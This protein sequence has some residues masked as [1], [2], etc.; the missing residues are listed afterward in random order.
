[1]TCSLLKRAD[2]QVLPICP[3]LEEPS[4]NW[5]WRQATG[6]AEAAEAAGHTVAVVA[7]DGLPVWV[8]ALA[9]RSRPHAAAVTALTT[10]TGQGPV[11]LT[12]DNPGAAG[13]L[14]TEIGIEQVH[15]NL[16]PTDTAYYCS[17]SAL[18]IPTTA[19]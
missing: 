6:A 13:R 9:D 18:G 15:A 12:G 4:A 2:T 11:L 1:M 16:L 8:L 7:I 10:L 14:A 17:M 3:G 5:V 19:V